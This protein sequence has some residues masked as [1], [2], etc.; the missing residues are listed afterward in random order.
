MYIFN[1]AAPQPVNST[2]TAPPA[3]TCLLGP[4]GTMVRLVE[5]HIVRDDETAGWGGGSL[6]NC[7]MNT[8]INLFGFRV[9]LGV[10]G[11]IAA[12]A[13]LRFGL[14]GLG[15]VGMAAGTSRGGMRS[16]K[17]FMFSNMLSVVELFCQPVPGTW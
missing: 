1:F 4:Q 10:A 14:P 12:F 15:F 16:D 8:R 9:P 13:L 11:A 2:I 3:S 5:G 6:L 7:S 17:M